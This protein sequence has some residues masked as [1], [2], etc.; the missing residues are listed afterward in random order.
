MQVNVVLIYSYSVYGKRFSVWAQPIRHII[1]SI[2]VFLHL[3]MSYG[4]TGKLGLMIVVKLVLICVT[5]QK[6]LESLRVS[7]G[8][9]RSALGKL[10]IAIGAGL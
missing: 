4:S 7:I 3:N 8:L 5:V 2:E 1:W 9:P 6:C 10:D